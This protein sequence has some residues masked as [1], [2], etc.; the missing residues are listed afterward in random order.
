MGKLDSFLFLYL[1]VPLVNESSTVISFNVSVT[2]LTEYIF[3]IKNVVLGGIF[4]WCLNIISA[5]DY[6]LKIERSP[7][8]QDFPGGSDG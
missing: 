7:H 1:S 6:L 3:K 8:I 2:V 4:V 5:S